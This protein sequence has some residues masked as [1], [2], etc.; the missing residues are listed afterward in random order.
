MHI[1]KRLP[2]LVDDSAVRPSLLHGDFWSGNFMVA[3]DGE[4]VLMDPAV[5]YGDRDTD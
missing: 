2:E 1:A 4:A 5:Y 3:S